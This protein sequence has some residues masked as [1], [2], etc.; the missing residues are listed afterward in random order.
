VTRPPLPNEIVPVGPEAAKETLIRLAGSEE[1]L[2]AYFLALRLEADAALTP[3]LKP[4]AGKPYPYGRCEEI[5][6]DVF[7]RLVARI[8]R[9]TNDI[10]RALRALAEEGG[11]IRRVWGALRGLYF[12]NA[13]QI[14]GLYVDVSNDTVVVTKPK[15]EILPIA[16]SGM[17]PIRDLTHFREIA[18]LYWG[19]TIYVNHLAPSLAPLLPMVSHAPGRLVPGFQSACDYMIALM[20]RDEFREAEAWVADG[21]LPPAEVAAV[22]AARIPPDLRA[23]TVDPRAEAIEACRRARVAG[24]STNARWRDARVLDYLRS[25]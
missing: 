21:P 14:G 25:V 23:W 13:F 20:C 16:E 15:I 4:A 9:P 22:V 10:D 7:T 12:Q 24:V 6:G 11:V 5:S 2:T 8:E 17:E 19:A 3:R 18:A 1:R